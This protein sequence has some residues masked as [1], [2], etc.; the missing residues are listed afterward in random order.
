[1]QWT[2]ART[3]NAIELRNR[4]FRP[5]IKTETVRPCAE[6]VP[7]LLWALLA[8]GQLAMRNVDGWETLSQPIEPFALD[9]AV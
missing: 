9:Q 6:T 2:S 5:G 1:M 8:A 3:T 4:E 7:M